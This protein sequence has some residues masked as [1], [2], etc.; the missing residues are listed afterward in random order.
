MILESS[1][2]TVGGKVIF[3][4]WTEVL[5]SDIF[6]VGLLKC[7]CPSTVSVLSVCF[8]VTCMCIV[9]ECHFNVTVVEM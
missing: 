3:T 7:G 8:L 6:S 4:Q 9:I 2:I 5:Y 1:D